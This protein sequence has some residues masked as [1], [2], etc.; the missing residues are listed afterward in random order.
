MTTNAARLSDADVAD[1]MVRLSSRPEPL[2]RPRGSVV[3]LDT[4]RR[5]LGLSIVRDAAD[6]PE[7]DDDGFGE[8]GSGPVMDLAA[9]D[10]SALNATP[11]MRFV[12][13]TLN[14]AVGLAENIAKK[15]TDGLRDEIAEARNLVRELQLERERDRATIA[16]M[17]SKVAEL[18]FVVSRL[19]VDN[20]G[21][22]GPAGPR[23][24]DGRDG[25]RGPRGERGA[26]GPAGPR[27]VSWE[28]ADESFTAT[29]L[30]SDGRKSAPLRLLG[31]FQEFSAQTEAADLAEEHD[32]VQAQRAVVEREAANRRAG[33]PAR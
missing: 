31:M 17:R 3:S 29:P 2:D 18:D 8:Y 16:E 23:G 6:E 5:P 28:T 9:M 14:V 27:I 4:K 25:A 11:D 26:Q 33:L 22:I 7:R 19:K 24:V 30:G 15:S 10:A 1:L 13:F 20:A 12:Y 21:P 32:A